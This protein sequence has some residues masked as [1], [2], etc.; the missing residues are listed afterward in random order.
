M[1]RPWTATHWV[2]LGAGAGIGV[3]VRVLLLPG[4]GL[5]GDMNEFASWIHGLATGPFGSAYDVDLTFPPVMVYVWGVLAAV[6]PAFRTVADASDPWIRVLMKLPPTLADVGLAAAVGFALRARPA[7]AVAGALGVWLHPAVIDVS[8]MFGQYESIYVLFALLAFLLVVADRPAL[9]VL[10]LATALMTKPQALPLL[11]PFGAWFLAREG[12]MQTARLALI[13]AIWIVVLWLP[14]L[15]AGGPA[16]YLRSIQL[17]QN[18]L[19]G[20]LS[21]RS[22]NVWWLFQEVAAGGAFI[23]DQARVL[24]P[25]TLRHL[26]WALAGAAELL[27]FLAVYRT[28]SHRSLAIGLA[29]STLVAVMLLTT[30]HERYA[31]PAVVFLALVLAEARLR[32][33]WAALGIVFTLNLLAA[34]PPSP[35]VGELLPVAGPFGIAGSLVMLGVTIAVLMAL[36]A[37]P[38]RAGPDSAPA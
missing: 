9:A 21:L 17:H 19:Y 31:Y 34:V 37:A 12:L 4:P 24:G 22:W 27:V 18:E 3:L 2:V 35:Q 30:M 32:W 14:F 10:L 5:A 1:Q 7:W 11:V 36:L 29:A 28:P 16:G 33:L 13:G 38:P 20:V 23:S 25:L 6:E 26:G 8:A 15:A